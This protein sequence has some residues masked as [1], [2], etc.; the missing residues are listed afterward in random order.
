VRRIVRSTRSLPLAQRQAGWARLQTAYLTL[1]DREA[2]EMMA[3][4]PE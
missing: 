2:A 1:G 4:V 3:S